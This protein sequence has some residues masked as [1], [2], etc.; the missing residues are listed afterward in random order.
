MSSSS[1]SH[2]TT[3]AVPVTASPAAAPVAAVAVAP[4]AAR[5]EEKKLVVPRVDTSAGAKRKEEQMLDF[6]LANAKKG[7]PQSVM[8]TIDAW[9]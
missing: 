1:T 2:T 4:V 7:D 6:V 9:G 8:D 3:P 5:V